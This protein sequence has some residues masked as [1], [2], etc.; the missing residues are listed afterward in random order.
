MTHDRCNWTFEPDGAGR[1]RVWHHV[2]PRF[3]AAWGSGAAVTDGPSWCNPG[4]G[5]GEDDLRFYSFRWL[6]PAPGSDVFEN[7]IREACVA[8]DAWIARQF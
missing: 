2:P 1:G 4:S 8:L 6:D 5:S 3:T 7:L